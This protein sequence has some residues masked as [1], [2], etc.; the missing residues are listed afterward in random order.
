MRFQNVVEFLRFSGEILNLF[1]VH[2]EVHMGLV[3]HHSISPHLHLEPGSTPSWMCH[4]QKATWCHTT[5][6]ALTGL[7]FS[8][9]SPT[10]PTS[11]NPFHSTNCFPVAKVMERES[12]DWRTPCQIPFGWVECVTLV[13]LHAGLRNSA[14]CCWNSSVF[15]PTSTTSVYFTFLQVHLQQPNPIAKM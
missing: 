13:S 8:L 4:S 5:S 6:A 14:R 10:A 11:P 9:L 12:A 3:E 1:W 2:V 15:Q 7:G